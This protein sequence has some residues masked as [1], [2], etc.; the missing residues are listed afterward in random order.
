MIWTPPPIANPDH[1]L[2]GLIIAEYI[3]VVLIYLEYQEWFMKI[4]HVADRTLLGVLF[5]YQ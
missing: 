5:Q 1:I 3:Q 4:L 2:V